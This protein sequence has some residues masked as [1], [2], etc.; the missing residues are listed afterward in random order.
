VAASPSVGQEA[1][2][3]TVSG[4]ATQSMLAVKR[5]TIAKALDDFLNSRIE[6]G[7]QIIYRNGIDELSFT[8]LEGPKDGQAELR[9]TTTGYIGPDLN[10]AQLAQEIKGKRYSETLNYIESRPG[11]VEVDVNFEPFWVFTTPRADR[12]EFVLN[13]DDGSGQ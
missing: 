7:D 8:L 13:V 1:E 3:G 5:D 9:L 2:T 12:I 4:E 10:T 6:G 11:V